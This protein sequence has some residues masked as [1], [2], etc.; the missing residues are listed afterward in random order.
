[1]RA[2]CRG[3]VLYLGLAVVLAVAMTLVQVGGDSFIFQSMPMIIA[4]V[5]LVFLFPFRNAS[6]STFFRSAFFGLFLAVSVN[7]SVGLS[8][9]DQTFVDGNYTRFAGLLV[10]YLT[11]MFVIAQ[12]GGTRQPRIHD[13]LTA[14]SLMATVMALSFAAAQLALSSENVEPDTNQNDDTNQL[15]IPSPL[16]RDTNAQLAACMYLVFGFYFNS[17][18]HARIVLFVSSAFGLWTVVPI[19]EYSSSEPFLGTLSAVFAI[20]AALLQLQNTHSRTI[21]VRDFSSCVFAQLI[22][23]ASECAGLP[24]QRIKQE[25]LGRIGIPFWSIGVRCACYC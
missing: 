21:E 5:V 16:V 23:H 17:Q 14:L 3:M 7:A 15:N 22:T 20:F 13:G 24:A 19:A 6:E 9:L 4:S 11:A 10:W 2:Y 8:A 12:C 25:I 1:M 18:D